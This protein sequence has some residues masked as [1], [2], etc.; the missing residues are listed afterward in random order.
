[1]GEE[2][3]CYTEEIIN[4]YYCNMENNDLSAVFCWTVLYPNKEGASFDF[5]HF[6]KMLIPEYVEILGDNCLKYEVR[7]GLATPGALA[8]NFV[9]IVNIW[10]TSR[11]KLRTSLADQRMKVL[12]EAI[13]AVTDIQP[14][15]QLDQV[16]ASR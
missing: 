4:E 16:I 3:W 5:E 9:C 6:S 12:M 2:E 10:V 1:M 13:S 7:K 14:I 15:R 8:P 11:E